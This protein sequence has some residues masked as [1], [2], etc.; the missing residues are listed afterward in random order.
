MIM[1]TMSVMVQ[2]KTLIFLGG[3]PVTTHFC[4]SSKYGVDNSGCLVPTV[5]DYSYNE[6]IALSGMEA[7]SGIG[8][9]ILLL[10][11]TPGISNNGFKPRAFGFS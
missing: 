9:P 10:A 7:L 6:T 3:Y 5:C 8:E 11:M 4:G 1:D 2:T